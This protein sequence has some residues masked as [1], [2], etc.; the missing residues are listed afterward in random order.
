MGAVT[1]LL[2]VKLFGIFYLNILARE[3]GRGWGGG[4][5]GGGIKLNSA[6]YIMKKRK[7]EGVIEVALNGVCPS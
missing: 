1:A 6:H 2:S 5:W 7:R 3:W 4:V